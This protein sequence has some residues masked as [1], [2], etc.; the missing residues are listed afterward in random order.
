M[1]N[2]QKATDLYKSWMELVKLKESMGSK[3][4]EIAA[5]P[6]A[7]ADDLATV[8]PRYRDVVQKLRKHKPVVIEALNKLHPVLAGYVADKK[9]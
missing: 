9:L 7:T 3:V 8:A 6:D 5:H 4:L 2:K 1:N